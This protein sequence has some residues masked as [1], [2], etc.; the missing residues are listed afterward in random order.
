VPSSVVRKMLTLLGAPAI[1]IGS[2]LITLKVM[3]YWETP[4]GTILIRTATYGGNC[5]AA[6]G[7]ASR[8]I[9]ATCDGKES[10][11]YYVDVAKLGDPSA[12]CQKNYSV[13]YFCSPNTDPRT[14]RLPAEANGKAVHISCD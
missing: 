5:H 3:D 4:P 10:C 7:N 2:F 8:S 12:G 1:V 9:K 6:A 14:L 13:E 11:T